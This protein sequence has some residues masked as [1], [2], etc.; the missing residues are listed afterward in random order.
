MARGR[1]RGAKSQVS[2]TGVLLL[3]ADVEVEKRQS[4][5]TEKGKQYHEQ[6]EQRMRQ[7]Y[8]DERTWQIDC[9]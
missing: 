1:A 2:R 3:P 8:S 4:P 6:L 7:G 5:Q 9:V